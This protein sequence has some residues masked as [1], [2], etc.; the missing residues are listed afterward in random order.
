MNETSFSLQAI[1]IMHKNPNSRSV[2]TR[3][4]LK[5]LPSSRFRKNKFQ[6]FDIKLCDE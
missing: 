5:K 4:Q 1:I 6:T 3:A 2:F